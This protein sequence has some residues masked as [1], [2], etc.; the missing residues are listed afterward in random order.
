MLG[1]NKNSENQKLIEEAIDLW[2][3]II[4]ALIEFE[5]IKIQKI[6]QK[7][8]EKTSTKVKPKTKTNS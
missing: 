5:K 1:K 6:E 8:N 4:I 7:T 3:R 2:A